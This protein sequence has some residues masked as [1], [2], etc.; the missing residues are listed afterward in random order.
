MSSAI[1]L[2][3]LKTPVRSLSKLTLWRN[4]VAPCQ[5]GY[6]KLRNGF[7]LSLIRESSLGCPCKLFTME[8]LCSQLTL[9]L[10]FLAKLLHQRGALLL[11][12]LQSVSMS[13]RSDTPFRIASITKAFTA[14]LAYQAVDDG[15]MKLGDPV[16]SLL[17][18]FAYVDPFDHG[19]QITFRD[20]MAHVSG[21]QRDMPCL[22]GCTGST[23]E[24][25]EKIAGSMLTHRIGE[26]PSYSNLGFAVLGHA[27][28]EGAYD[29]T[30]GEVLSENVIARLGL[31]NTGLNVTEAVRARMAVGYSGGSL[32]YGSNLHWTS[33]A[34]QM[35]ASAND[36]STVLSSLMRDD[37]LLSAPLRSEWLDSARYS[38][39]DGTAFGGSW[40]IVNLK[41]GGYNI[42]TKS[43]GIG[44][45][46]T[47]MSMIPSLKLGVVFLFN[48]NTQPRPLTVSVFEKVVP[49]LVDYLEPLQQGP[50]VNNPS[51]YVGTYKYFLNPAFQ[52]SINYNEKANILGGAFHVNGNYGFYLKNAPG[53]Y[54]DDKRVL[55]LS[56]PPQAKISCFLKAGLAF[57]DQYVYF[58]FSSVNGT[59]KSVQVPGFFGDKLVLTR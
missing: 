27:V 45:F 46:S 40:E 23:P 16:T 25:L 41:N 58:D 22:S 38:Y 52:V 53:R 2:L 48:Q 51:L 15:L 55:Q 28:A 57:Y 36:L 10:A 9:A 43:G 18:D 5:K 13:T 26:Y 42:V 35:Y 20:L 50:V 11:R 33:P 31:S 37:T 54:Q 8:N 21:L 7:G 59:A 34:G 19:E 32:T 17:P 14:L 56:L 12:Y 4:R 39:R 30:F 44:G 49:L 3:A 29:S 24:N 47:E 6:M 1:Y